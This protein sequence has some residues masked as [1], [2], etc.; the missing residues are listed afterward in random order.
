MNKISLDE[1]TLRTQCHN[2]ASI[3]VDALI[4][5]GILQE[6]DAEQ[7]VGIVEEELS[8]RKAMGKL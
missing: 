3:V 6:M 4:M 5:A 8:V 2:A 1:Q 7:A